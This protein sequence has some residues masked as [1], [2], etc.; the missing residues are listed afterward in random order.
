M[1]NKMFYQIEDKKL[2][3]TILKTKRKILST[4]YQLFSTVGIFRTTMVD[5]SE[6][7]EITRRT[8]YNHYDTKE[9]IAMELHRLLL[10]DLILNLTSLED[11]SNITAKALFTYL[12]QLYSNIVSD[13]NKLQYIVRFDQFAQENSNII[14]IENHFVQYLCSNSSV[15]PYL[16]AFEERGCFLDDTVPPELLTKVIFESFLAYMERVLYREASYI[17]EGFYVKSDLE[18]LINTLM[19]VLPEGECFEP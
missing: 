6:T 7:A 16:K 9:E 13:K 15:L 3:R 12:H 4:S 19:T 1:Y 8:L 14:E 10:Q 11:L 18:L 17:E 5:I 2:T